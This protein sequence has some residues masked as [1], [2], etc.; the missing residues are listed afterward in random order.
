MPD[1]IQRRFVVKRGERE[2]VYPFTTWSYIFKKCDKGASIHEQRLMEYLKKVF[3]FGCPADERRVSVTSA[4]EIFVKTKEVDSGLIAAAEHAEYRKQ[5][6]YQHDIVQQ[7]LL[8]NDHKTVAIEVPV[9]DDELAGHIDIIRILHGV[10]QVADFKPEAHREKV[11]GSQV[12]RYI[13]L[14]AKATRLPL[15]AFQ[16]IYFDD[17]KA[18]QL[19]F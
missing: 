15:S 4:R 11:A 14:L 18:Y 12:K 19:I 2:V 9:W 10:I 3:V 13:D 5:G 17:R 7:Y 16:G 8:K 1:I 6:R